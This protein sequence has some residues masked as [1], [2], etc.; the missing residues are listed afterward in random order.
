MLELLP[1]RI[2]RMFPIIMRQR[3]GF[4]VRLF[5]YVITGLYQGQNF[6]ELSAGIASMNFREFMR[7]NPDSGDFENYIFCSFPGNDMLMDLFL[8]QFEKNKNL[9]ECDMNKRVG[10]ILSCDHTVKTS[11]YIGVTRDGDH[12]FVR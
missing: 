11:K 4:T 1:S 9:Y 6:L 7:N 3:S 8:Q 12:K 10:K 5:D 2:S